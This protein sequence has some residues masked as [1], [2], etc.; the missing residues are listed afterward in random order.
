MT[1]IIH[2]GTLWTFILFGSVFIAAAEVD[3]VEVSVIEDEVEGDSFQPD[4]WGSNDKIRLTDVIVVTLHP[5]K[6]TNSRRTHPVP[7]L[8]CVGGMTDCSAFTP[9][10]VHCLNIGSDG[11]D[12]QW[13]CPTYMNNR[14]KFGEIAVNCEGY[15]YPDDPYVLEGSCWLEYTIDFVDHGG[16]YYITRNFGSWLGSMFRIIALVGSIIMFGIIA[17][18]AYY[19]YLHLTEHSG[20]WLDIMF[21]IIAS[22]PSYINRLL[23]CD[24]SQ[25]YV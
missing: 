13:E 14:Y 12:V 18:V 25:Q 24:P 3:D 11:S 15:D 4:G 1:S 20:S 5:G 16:H 2:S 10:V 7:Q 19:I 9:S 8:K 22:V 23:K 17:L 6:M 21:D